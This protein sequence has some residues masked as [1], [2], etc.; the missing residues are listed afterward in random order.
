MVPKSSR[1]MDVQKQLCIE[2][3]LVEEQVVL[4]SV[5]WSKTIQF[6]QR[7]IHLPMLPTPDPRLNPILALRDLWA[8]AGT[9]HPKQQAFGIWKNG[10]IH[11]LTY[12][13]LRAQ[14]KTWVQD[15][16]EDPMNFSLH[17]LRRGSAT[18][19][20]A[21]EIPGEVIQSHGDWAS[22]AYLK[23]ISVSLNHRIRV[24]QALRD[25]SSSTELPLPPAQ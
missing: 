13:K 14:F 15:A 2:D 8:S 21:A 18:L 19:A 16:G 4:V 12:Y 6:G 3:F 20:F 7:H 25:W 17:S 23:Y 22:D 9:L 11:T 1:G 10:R 5:K 24:A